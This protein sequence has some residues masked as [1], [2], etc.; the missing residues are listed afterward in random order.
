ML[1]GKYPLNMYAAGCICLSYNF[2]PL[3]LFGMNHAV[4]NTY[5]TNKLLCILI[6]LLTF[7]AYY[8]ALKNK[9]TRWDDIQYTLE[10]SYTQNLSFENIKY[11]FTTSYQGNYI[12]L[13]YLSFTIDRAL[14]GDNP[15]GFIA[16]NILLHLINTL[17]VY[18]LIDR[19]TNNK[20]VGF[21]GSCLFGIPYACRICSMDSR[22][23]RRAICLLLFFIT[24][25]IY[26]LCRNKKSKMAT[27]LYC[28]NGIECIK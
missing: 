27:Y 17:M 15:K 20:L 22:K 9:W 8:P 2:Y 14:L 13:T 5:K 28:R 16:I 18:L 12:P 3:P 1:L 4:Q 21:V 7:F 26:Y 24:A 25:C 11:V 19:L 23:K 6:L 10:N